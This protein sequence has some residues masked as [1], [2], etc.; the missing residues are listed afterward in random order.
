MTATSPH[1]R[2]SIRAANDHLLGGG[3][4][5]SGKG[6]MSREGAVFLGSRFGIARRCPS[7]I[8]IREPGRDR[9]ALDKDDLGMFAITY[10]AAEGARPALPTHR[11]A[12]LPCGRHPRRDRASAPGIPLTGL[13]GSPPGNL[14]RPDILSPPRLVQSAR[15]M[16]CGASACECLD[17]RRRMAFSL[18]NVVRTPSPKMVPLYAARVSDLKSGDFVRGECVCGHDE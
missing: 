7:F 17:E 12:G 11:T 6:R 5:A 16:G 8:P 2:R 1:S 15:Q 10:V 13:P 9:P 18:R 3:V 14:A 4:A